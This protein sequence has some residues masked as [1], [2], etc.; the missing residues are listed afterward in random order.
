MCLSTV[1]CGD[2]GMLSRW[3]DRSYGGVPP[4]HET[5]VFYPLHPDIRPKYPMALSPRMGPEYP[6][7]FPLDTGSGYSTPTIDIWWTSLE[8]CPNLFTVL[9]PSGGHKNTFSWQVDS[10]HPT[11]MRSCAWWSLVRLSCRNMNSSVHT[12]IRW[13]LLGSYIFFITTSLDTVDADLLLR[14]CTTCWVPNY[15]Y[16][17]CCCSLL[18]SC[19]SL[20]LLY[21]TVQGLKYAPT[22]SIIVCLLEL[23]GCVFMTFCR[24]PGS[25]VADSLTVLIWDSSCLD[26]S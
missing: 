26:V 23:I 20:L 18:L 10:M 5:W 12:E 7:P 4:G 3:L 25:N 16:W 13:L 2:G 21:C 24:A 14:L 9:T 6:T 11:G 22:V 17:L 8:S 19:H 1:G 15:C